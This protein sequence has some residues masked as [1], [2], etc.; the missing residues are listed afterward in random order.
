MGCAGRANPR[1]PDA[2]DDFANS[3]R[4][5]SSRGVSLTVARD[6]LDGAAQ[7]AAAEGWSYTHFLGYLLDGELGERHRKRVELNLK[8]AR[9]PALKRLEGFDFAAQPG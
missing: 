5:F 2:Q 4:P 7:R 6:H 3:I 1:S 9:F 8:F